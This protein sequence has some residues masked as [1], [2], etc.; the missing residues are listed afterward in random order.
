[1]TTMNTCKVSVFDENTDKGWLGANQQWWFDPQFP[2]AFSIFDLDGFYEENYFKHDHVG[3]HIVE[4]YVSHVLDYGRKFLGREARSILE[5]GCGG[6]WFTEGFLKRGIDIVAVEGTHAGYNRALKRGVPSHLLIR[7]DLRKALALN[8]SFDMVVCTEVAEHIECPFSS[9]LVQNIVN[10]GRVAWFSFEAP[11]TNDAHYHHCNEQPER[12]WKNLFK[13]YGYNMWKL[14]AEV[15]DAVQ[16]RGNIIFYSQDLVLSP[17]LAAPSEEDNSVGT[18][19][20]RS[21]PAIETSVAGRTKAAVKQLV[22]PILW[23]GIRRLKS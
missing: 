18:S 13:F 10:H 9:Q 7:H 8:R 21:A 16:G 14:P 2:H 19:L 23:D 15:C 6:G 12:F 17:E 3:P 4:G 22:P 11:G 20:G 5:L 1:M